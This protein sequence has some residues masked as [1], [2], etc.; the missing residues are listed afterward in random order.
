SMFHVKHSAEPGWAPLSKGRSS[1]PCGRRN[2]SRETSGESD[3][4]EPDPKVVRRRIDWR[5]I[6]RVTGVG[7]GAD[8][9][10]DRGPRGSRGGPKVDWVPPATGE[11]PL[12]TNSP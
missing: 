10:A 7:T 4:L 5:G 2:V 3:R 1:S 11:A 8:V 6:E 9:G 12:R